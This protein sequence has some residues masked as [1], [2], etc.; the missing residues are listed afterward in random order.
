MKNRDILATSY[1]CLMFGIGEYL[2]DRFVSSVVLIIVA[3]SIGIYLVYQ[4]KARL[5]KPLAHETFIMLVLLIWSAVDIEVG[6]IGALLITLVI[7][8]KAIL[9]TIAIKD[10][11]AVYYFS[12]IML[13]VFL[14]CFLGL[15]ALFSNESIIEIKQ[16]ICYLVI[17]HFYSIMSIIN[18]VLVRY[19]QGKG[20]NYKNV[21]DDYH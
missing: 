8:L 3:V 15:S 19:R 18:L 21:I 13:M 12:I 5:T 4:R 14:I 17:F 11:I 1:G 10:R 16:L 6:I 9:P 2:N 7:I 20:V